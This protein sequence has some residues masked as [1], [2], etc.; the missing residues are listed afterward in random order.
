MSGFLKFLLGMLIIGA[1]VVMT[2]KS[3]WF[4]ENFG[5]VAWA[6]EKLGSTR[7]FYKLLGIIISLLGMLVA[8]GLWGGFVRGSLGVLLTPR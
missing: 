1:G 6:E 2:I 8:T 4:Y 7:L 3:E 5:A